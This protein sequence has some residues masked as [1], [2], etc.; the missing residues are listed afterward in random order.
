M[1]FSRLA[2]VRHYFPPR[3]W[4][5]LGGATPMARA[6]PSFAR[7]WLYTLLMYWSLALASDCSDCTT[8]TLSVTPE[9]KRFFERARCSLAKATFFCA[10]STCSCVIQVTFLLPFNLIAS[11]FH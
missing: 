7:L 8:S 4:L 3:Y 5:Q 6:R 2:V 10:M 9:V 11:P 1:P